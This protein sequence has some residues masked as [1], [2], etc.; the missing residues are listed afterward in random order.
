MTC[1]HPPRRPVAAVNHE[2][3]IMSE[4][5]R[6][7]RELAFTLHAYLQTHGHPGAECEPDGT[8]YVLKLSPGAYIVAE[9]E[10]EADVRAILYSV[11]C[12]A[13]GGDT[14]AAEWLE[15]RG[16]V[17]LPTRADPEHEAAGESRV[18]GAY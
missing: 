10:R 18:A 7:P 3:Y 5:L 1:P 14:E 17:T 15:A 2:E 16:V 13:R 11:M 12:K 6:L 4:P 8:G 9:D